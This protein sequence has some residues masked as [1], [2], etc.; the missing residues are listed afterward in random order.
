L[1][2]AI[3][4]ARKQGARFWELR[5]ASALAEQWMKRG[6]TSDA[7]NLLAAVYGCFTQGL[8]GPDLK[9]AAAL[10]AQPS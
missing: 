9:R 5:A 10:L 4:L 3:A 2:D 6:R 1:L 8:D 7:R